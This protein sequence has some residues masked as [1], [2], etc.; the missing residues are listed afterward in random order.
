[1]GDLPPQMID[2][3]ALRLSAV[4]GG[5]CL[6]GGGPETHDLTDPQSYQSHL[7]DKNGDGRRD[8]TLHFSLSGSGLRVG[9][10]EVCIKGA[11][12]F[13]VGEFPVTTFEARAPVNVK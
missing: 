3:T 7:V 10:Q 1:V 2:P 12:R 8:L 4:E 6:P 13:P 9:S 11:F 5:R